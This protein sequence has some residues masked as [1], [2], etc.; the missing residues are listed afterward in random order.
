M[1]VPRR[2]FLQVGGVAAV[3][4]LAGCI[5]HGPFQNI[6]LDIEVGEPFETAPPV[7]IPLTL[8]VD[9]QG[10]GEPTVGLGDVEVVGLDE[11]RSQLGDQFVGDITLAGAAPAD[12]HHETVDGTL[13]F[14]SRDV[15]TASRTFELDLVLDSVPALITVDVK[16]GWF[17]TDFDEDHADQESSTDSSTGGVVSDGSDSSGAAVSSSGPTG[18]QSA[19]TELPYQPIGRAR[20][21]QPPPELRASVP[22]YVG[23][24]EPPATVGPDE[25]ESELVEV[26]H[27][28][29][30]PHVL[31]DPLHQDSEPGEP[32]EVIDSSR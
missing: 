32:R 5:Y 29:R 15:Y 6:S 28:Y 10:L 27:L 26:W 1:G 11:E 19:D 16:R 8:S 22:R 23:P 13:P 20:A 7:S 14:T 30:L 31:D 25:F 12:R 3:A 4:G 21:S 18:A 17:S 9:L 2:R 24:T